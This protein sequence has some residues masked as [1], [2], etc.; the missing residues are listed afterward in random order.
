MYHKPGTCILY[1]LDAWHRG[2]PA[3]LGQ[4]RQS[5]HHVWRR[6]DAAWVNWQSLAPRM[7]R[8]PTRY[9]AGL[10]VLQRTVLGFAAP[11]DPYWNKETIDA[12]GQRYPGM[13]MSAY[14]DALD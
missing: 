1:R 12:V 14:R 10:S 2:T 7:S 4:V 3:A 6:R 8:M 5:H 11:G 13:D 9:M